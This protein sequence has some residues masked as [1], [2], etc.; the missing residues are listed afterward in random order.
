MTKTISQTK[1]L[2]LYKSEVL[3]LIQDKKELLEMSDLQITTNLKQGEL[4]GASLK[5]IISLNRKV[6]D[7]NFNTIV[8]AG[9]LVGMCLVTILVSLL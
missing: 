4:L 2:E 6:K 7:A 3:R 5:S 1:E 8:L 9:C